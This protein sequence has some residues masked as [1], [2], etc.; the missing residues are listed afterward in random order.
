[1]AGNLALELITLN[2]WSIAVIAVFLIGIVAM[3][4]PAVLWR[5]MGRLEINAPAWLLLLLTGVVFLSLNT[6]VHHIEQLILLTRPAESPKS[7]LDQVD[8]TFGFIW[9]GFGAPPTVETHL[10]SALTLGSIGLIGTILLYRLRYSVFELDIDQRYDAPPRR[11]IIMALS[12]PY[13]RAAASSPNDPKTQEAHRNYQ[14]A[15]A[16]LATLS[17]PEASSANVGRFP[18]QQNLR[19]LAHHLCRPL[20]KPKRF[21]SRRRRTSRVVVVLPS[22]ET[23]HFMQAF[24][25]LVHSTLEKTEIKDEVRVIPWDR[26][27][28]YNV[29]EALHS[30]LEAII[31]HVRSDPEIAAEYAEISID[32]TPGL[33]LVSIAGAVATFASPMEFTYVETAPPYEVVSFDASAAFRLPRH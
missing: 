9:K 29:L 22:L 15:L 33:K 17:L 1:M 19:L 23:R 20:P 32:T 14:Q 30:E 13:Q 16:K 12:E 18:W 11:V 2:H 31:S 24:L 8:Y 6:T 25:D 10:I 21:A 7:L 28:N 26:G 3:R 27:V 4:W 5:H